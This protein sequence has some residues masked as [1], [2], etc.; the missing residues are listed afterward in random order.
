MDF[1]SFSANSLFLCHIDHTKK[2]S[3]RFPLNLQE[4]HFV[5]PP[6]HVDSSFKAGKISVLLKDTPAGQMLITMAWIQASY[7]TSVMQAW[8][9]P[10]KNLWVHLIYNETPTLSV[11]FHK[12]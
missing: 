8:C 10:L 2:H 9:H 3:V 7:N 4:N 6:Q 5:C 12:K 1:G 11:L